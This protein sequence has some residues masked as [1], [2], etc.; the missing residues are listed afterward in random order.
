MKNRIL[1]LFLAALM[2]VCTATGLAPTASAEGGKDRGHYIDPYQTKNAAVYKLGDEELESTFGM[3][4]VRYP[5]GVAIRAGDGIGE[6]CYNLQS[7]YRVFAFDLGSC[8][9]EDGQTEIFIYADGELFETITV[10]H[11]METTHFTLNVSGFSQLRF[12]QTSSTRWH[13]IANTRALTAT[14]ATKEN[15]AVPVRYSTEKVINSSH[16]PDDK[17]ATPYRTSDLFRVYK[18][19]D[20]EIE[21]TFSMMGI[22]Y[23]QGIASMSWTISTKHDI[24][25][26][27][28]YNLGCLFETMEFDVGHIDGEESSD[29]KIEIHTDGTLVKAIPCT[30]FMETEKVSLNTAGV[31]QV[32]LRLIITRDW[33]NYSYGIGNVTL[34]HTHEWESEPTLDTA[35]SCLKDGA[36]SI[37][38]KTC[39]KSDKATATLIDA[40]GH[41]FS[42]GV[43]KRCG[44]NETS[45]GDANGDGKLNARDITAIMRYLLDVS[46]V[47]ENFSGAAADFNGDGT[48][49]ARD[50]TAIMREILKN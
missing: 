46:K 50:I 26:N 43:C 37:H 6:A 9:G 15:I 30:S 22:T 34:T 29:C 28:M 20:E 4:G 13:G 1:S 3:M 25:E 38:C 35:P 5:Q 7:L 31:N 16:D 33:G 23:Y 18:L 32:I 42:G 39:G 11:D 27:C 10:R 40:L 12:V 41:D 21:S 45:P 44:Q 2:L 24:I 48:I 14:E 47:P 36:Q 8:N 19:G 17:Y 49:N